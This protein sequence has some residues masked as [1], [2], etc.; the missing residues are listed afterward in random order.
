MNN[1]DDCGLEVNVVVTGVG[2]SEAGKVVLTGEVVWLASV[3]LVLV[4]CL[5]GLAA[6]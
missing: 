4:G 6:Q 2:V 3:S 1:T 5:T